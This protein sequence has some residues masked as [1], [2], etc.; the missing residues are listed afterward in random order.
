ML[1]FPALPDKTPRVARCLMARITSA[2]RG[3]LNAD[4]TKRVLNLTPVYR[5]IVMTSLVFLSAL[6][7]FSVIYYILFIIDGEVRWIGPKQRG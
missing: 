3:L 6:G 5:S 1:I 2:L 4:E 7:Y